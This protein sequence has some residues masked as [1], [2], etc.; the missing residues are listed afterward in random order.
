[1][2][3]INCS[4]PCLSIRYYFLI[5]NKKITGVQLDAL[6]DES[7]SNVFIDCDDHRISSVDDARMSFLLK[8]GKVFN[9]H[10]QD[11]SI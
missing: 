11:A 4:P 9:N 8:N 7:F 10:C 1:M 6:I 2:N 5:L 3:R